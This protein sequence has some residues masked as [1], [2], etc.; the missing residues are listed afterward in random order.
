MI[1]NIVTGIIQEKKKY[2]TYLTRTVDLR[3]N[4]ETVWRNSGNI[5]AGQNCFEM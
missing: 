5:L 1:S 3:D 2:A 4:D